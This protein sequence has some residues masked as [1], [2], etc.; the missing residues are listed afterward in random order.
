MNKKLLLLIVTIFCGLL[1][2]ISRNSTSKA[3]NGTLLL[4]G[5][6]NVVLKADPIDVPEVSWFKV[7]ATYEGDTTVLKGRQTA[8]GYR[9]GSK[10]DALF[11]ALPSRSALDR[12]VEVRYKGKVAR[13]PVW[14]VGPHNIR[15]DYWNHDGI[16]KAAK[17]IRERGMGGPPKN[18]AGMDL[19]DAL[20]DLLGIPKRIGVAEVEWRFVE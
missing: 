15:D 19:S 8:N 6:P 7:M 4:D 2:F 17:G 9:C 16:P 1:I 13:V 10:P 12:E 5:Q 18:K 20:W 3:G 14:D 11:V